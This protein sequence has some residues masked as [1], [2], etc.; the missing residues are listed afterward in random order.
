MQRPDPGHSEEFLESRVHG[1]KRKELGCEGAFGAHGRPKPRR[2]RG[3]GAA[4]SAP[5]CE[6]LVSAGKDGR[7]GGGE[8]RV[9]PAAAVQGTRRSDPSQWPER[10]SRNKRGCRRRRRNDRI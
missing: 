6:R 8:T 1:G 7:G 5:S 9:A 4:R 3:A 10:W 2:F